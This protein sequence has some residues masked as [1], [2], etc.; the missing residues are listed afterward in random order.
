[1]KKRYSIPL[2]LIAVI[3]IFFVWI[4]NEVSVYRCDSIIDNDHPLKYLCK[5]YYFEDK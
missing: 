2:V 4:L 1:M 3:F 5:S